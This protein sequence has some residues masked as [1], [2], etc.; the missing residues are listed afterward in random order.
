MPIGF[1]Y[2]PMFPIKQL[3]LLIVGTG[4]ASGA[5]AATMNEAVTSAARNHQT[6]QVVL[7]G[8]TTQV[9]YVGQ[10][11]GCDAVSLR[12]PGGHDQHFRVCGE[13]VI[14][15]HTV[16]P[17]WPDSPANKRALAVVV[18]NAALY[19]QADQTD[20]DGYLIQAQTLGSM[21][22]TCKNLEVIISFDADLVDHSLKKVC[23]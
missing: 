20:E 16:A 8:H 18:Q 7:N 4:L 12:S 1:L 14:P 6:R 9:I 17:T 19:G 11:G 22:T 13:H 23:Q 5:L 10:V 2:N 3:L 15:R 21:T